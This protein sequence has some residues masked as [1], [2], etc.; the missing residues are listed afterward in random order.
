MSD[1]R[2][3]TPDNLGGDFRGVGAKIV[4]DSI[5]GGTGPPTGAPAEPDKVWLYIDT[6]L[7]MTTHYWD[8]VAGAWVAFV[9]ALPSVARLHITNTDT[10]TNLIST[11]V[12]P[13]D[14]AFG[15]VNFN[16]G[17][18][19]V[20]LT[21]AEITLPETGWY[22]VHGYWSTL[23]GTNSNSARNNLS[24]SIRLNGAQVSP[25]FQDGYVRDASGNNETGQGITGFEFL[26]TAGD[27]LQLMRQRVSGAGGVQLLQGTNNYFT[28]SRI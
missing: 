2:L 8:A 7:G 16:V 25:S 23:A 20:D 4:N 12:T 24:L 3:V 21:T 22:R 14:E 18:F 13:F 26:A 11:A 27:V 10:T 6:T 17:G 28:I 15:T 9:S 5:L 1:A 19:S